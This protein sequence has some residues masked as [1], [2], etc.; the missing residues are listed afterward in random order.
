VKAI[1]LEHIQALERKIAELRSMTETLKHLAHTCHGDARPDCP[2]LEELA[3]AEVVHDCAKRETVFGLARTP[4]R[5]GSKA[6]QGS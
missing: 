5:T 6:G 2:I 3:G 1:A 4:H